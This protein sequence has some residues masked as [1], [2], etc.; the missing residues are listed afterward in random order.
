MDTS[1]FVLD[2]CKAFI[3]LFMFMSSSL[4]LF[5]SLIKCMNN[6]KNLMEKIPK[7]KNI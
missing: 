7:I 1:F 4:C 6:K 5:I 2:I 3:Y